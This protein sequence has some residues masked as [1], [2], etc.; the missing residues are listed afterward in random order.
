MAVQQTKAYAKGYAH[1]VCDTIVYVSATVEVWLDEFNC[2]AEGR[3]T[4]E[5]R[6]QTN[7]A[8]SGEGERQGCKGYEMHQFVVPPSAPGVVGPVARASQPSE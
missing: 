2:A 3:G 5:D 8:R 1:D 4:D 6:K 7:T